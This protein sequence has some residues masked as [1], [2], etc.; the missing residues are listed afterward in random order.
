[1][2]IKPIDMQV[3]VAQMH[4]VAKSSQVRTEAIVDQQHV[5]DKESV[6]KGNLIASKL[7]ENKKAERTVILREEKKGR[8]RGEQPGEHKE[9]DQNK[10][11]EEHEARDERMGRIIDVKK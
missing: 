8:H 11:D 2:S 9:G 4:E 6:D 1:M 3:N 5:L 7:E 10:R